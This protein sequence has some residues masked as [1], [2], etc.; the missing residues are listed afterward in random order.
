MIRAKHL[1]DVTFD[2]AGILSKR[3]VRSTHSDPAKI[4]QI[5]EEQQKMLHGQTMQPYQPEGVVT[6]T[7]RAAPLPPKLATTSASQAIREAQ[8]K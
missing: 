5:M 2:A 6:V 7:R 3:V 1:Y 8:G 4:K